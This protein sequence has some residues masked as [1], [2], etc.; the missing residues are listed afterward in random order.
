VSLAEVIH[1]LNETQFS[2]YLRESELAFPVSEAIHLIGLGISVGAIMFV[3]L[4]LLGLVLTKDRV[5]DV[6]ARIERW[7]VP[8]FIIVF[9]SGILLF[10]GKPE[11]YYYV[12]AFRIKTILLPLAGLNVLFFHKRVF[13][14][15]ADW[16]RAGMSVPWQ[17]KLVGGLSLMFWL[18]ITVLGRWTAYFVD[19]LYTAGFSH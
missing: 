2:V 16:D 11:D 18:V 8:G 12:T 7:A 19:P 4:R 6:V 14:H 15:M 10:L 9:A 17:G 3:D 13:P 5:A 1:W